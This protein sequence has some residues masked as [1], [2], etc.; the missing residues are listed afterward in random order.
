[1]TPFKLKILTPDG[2]L[3]EGDAASITAPTENGDVQILA[4]HADYLASL[5]TGTA[6][7]MLPDGGVRTAACSGGFISVLCGEVNLAATTFEFKEDIDLDRAL[8]AEKRARAEL[9]SASDERLERI[10]KA[11]INRAVSRIRVAKSK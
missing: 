9:A 8:S 7:L 10:A 4:R 1:M 11:K 5:G 6:R 3:F 2:I